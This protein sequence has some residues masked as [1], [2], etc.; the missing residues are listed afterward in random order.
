MKPIRQG[1]RGPA[2]EDIQRRL[3]VLGYDVGPSGV[4]GVFLE[5]TV[6]A[7]RAFQEKSALY[8]DGAVGPR[9]W[10]ALVDSTFNFG[11]RMLY[12]RTPFFHGNDVSE[13]QRALNAL[14]FNCGPV[15]G[16]F[17]G[18]TE[19]AVTEFQSN[20]G[21]ATDG[22]VGPDTFAGLNSLRHIWSSRNPTVHSAASGGPVD[23]TGVLAA[24]DL[25]VL[26]HDGLTKQVARRI[27]N[28]ALASYEGARVAVAPVH[29]YC[30]ASGSSERGAD[31]GYPSEHQVQRVV[32]ELRPAELPSVPGA[33]GVPVDPSCERIEL[34]LRPDRRA[35]AALLRSAV[36]GVRE[37]NL[38][39][40]VTIGNEPFTKGSKQGFQNASVSILDAICT[41]LARPS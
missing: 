34:A 31:C 36:A 13:L 3:T 29:D 38:H 2:V 16:I 24:T 20:Y 4:D 33:E 11:D 18:W 27:Q 19:R 6:T 28:L 5:D 39:I 30:A 21:L 7:V 1:A 12:L 25:S 26:Y 17:G 15:D 41:V 14:G 35:M 32:V 9:T 40:V 22:V 37:R 10:S 8:V 23:R